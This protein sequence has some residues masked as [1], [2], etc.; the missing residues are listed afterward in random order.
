M[1]RDQAEAAAKLI[2]S[3]LPTQARVKVF[4]HGSST[5]AGYFLS[6]V[7][8]GEQSV[9][10]NVEGVAD[11]IKRVVNGGRDSGT[12]APVTTGATTPASHAS[13]GTTG[14]GARQS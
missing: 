5:P 7:K 11:Y 6:I 4:N 1:K 13:N 9:V 8:G 10:H 14:N 12:T 3:V 2:Q